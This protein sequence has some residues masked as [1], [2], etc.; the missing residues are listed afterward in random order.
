MLV[1]SGAGLIPGTFSA[2][3]VKVKRRHLRPNLRDA[4]RALLS[5]YHRPHEARQALRDI[6]FDEL[7]ID[8]TLRRHQHHH[9][10]PKAYV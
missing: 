1:E 9:T 6:G 3:Y 10:Q 4:A 5:G 2:Y 8:V 7:E